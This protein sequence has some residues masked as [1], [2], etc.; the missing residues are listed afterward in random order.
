MTFDDDAPFGDD[1][2]TTYAQARAV[3]AS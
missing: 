1:E 3:Q 2:P